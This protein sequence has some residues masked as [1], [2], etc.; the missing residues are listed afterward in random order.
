MV[1]GRHCRSRYY[2][3]HENKEHF[4]LNQSITIWN[5]ENFTYSCEWLHFR[6]VANDNICVS[7]C[8]DSR[9]F[10]W[11]Y[12]ITQ[13]G[14]KSIP[15]P[16]RMLLLDIFHLSSKIRSAYVLLPES[17]RCIKRAKY[18]IKMTIEIHKNGNNTQN[19]IRMRRLATYAITTYRLPWFVQSVQRTEQMPIEQTI[20]ITQGRNRAILIHFP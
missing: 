20:K 15:F 16:I 8:D 5:V 9:L 4:K 18:H 6:I 13:A 7:D 14:M 1:N 17:T 2:I 11:W 3:F 10:G 19:T 12:I